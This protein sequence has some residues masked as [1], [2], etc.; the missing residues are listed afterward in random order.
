MDV[1]SF[2]AGGTV[3]FGASG[4]FVSPP[5]CGSPCAGEV[6]SGVVR[7]GSFLLSAAV[8]GTA[9]PAVGFAS[10]ELSAASLVSGAELA[11]VCS[12]RSL[13]ILLS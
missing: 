5:P 7:A 2:G 12:Y 10:V 8:S 6:V 13:Q 1:G 4:S 11:E 9:V 3:S